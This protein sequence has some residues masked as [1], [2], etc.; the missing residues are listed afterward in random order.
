M[1]TGKQ[2]FVGA[3]EPEHSVSMQREKEMRVQAPLTDMYI[4]AMPGL[5]THPPTQPTALQDAA[6]VSLPVLMMCTNQA[7]PILTLHIASGAA[8]QQQRPETPASSPKPK[9]AGKH[10]CPH[11]GRDC[12]KPSVL[13][14]HLRCHTGERPYPCTTCGISFKTQSNLYKHKRTQ[15]HA[16]LSG[17]T[18]KADFSSQE[19]TE[20]SRETCSSPSLELQREENSGDLNRSDSVLPSTTTTTFSTGILAEGK[21]ASNTE[22]ALR[23]AA[24]VGLIAS[25]AHGQQEILNSAGQTVQSA[26]EAK[27]E[28]P[29]IQT[30]S[31]AGDRR[32]PLTPNRTPLQRQEALFPKLCRGKSQ[33][34]DST[35]SGFSESSEQHLTSSPTDTMHDTSMESLPESNMELQEPGSSKKPTDLAVDDGKSKVSVQ[36]KQ[37]LEEHISKLISENSMLVDDKHLVNVRPRKTVLSKQGSIDLPMP[38]TY[39][40][41]FHFE[42][43]SSKHQVSSLQ[44]QDRRGRAMYSSVPTQHSTSLEHAPLT[45]SSS[46]PFSVGIQ[47][48]DRT[49]FPYQ[50]DSLPLSRRC[51]AGNIYPFKSVDQQAQNHRSLVRQV[52]VDCLSVAE[53]SLVERGSQNSLSSDGDCAD[54][55]TESGVKRCRRKKT[56]KFAYNKW[57]MYGDGTFKK[58]YSTEKDNLLKCRKATPSLEQTENQ[59]IQISQQRDSNSSASV[60]FT[61]CPT[62]S[63][64]AVNT[65]TAQTS[66]PVISSF[67]PLL[68]SPPLT[69]QTTG[70]LQQ[71]LAKHADV[72]GSSLNNE[73]SFMKGTED[74]GKG[75]ETQ[76]SNPIPSERKKPKTEED[77]SVVM[78]NTAMLMRQKRALTSVSR[79]ANVNP[80]DIINQPLQSVCG[81]VF[82]RSSVA[83]VEKDNRLNLH[84]QG[85]F[86]SPSSSNQAQLL[87][88]RHSSPLFVTSVSGTSGSPSATSSISSVSQAKTSFLPKYQLKI[89]GSTDGVSDPCVCNRSSL[90]QS[91]PSKT[92]KLSH[93]SAQQCDAD[94]SLSPTLTDQSAAT[95]MVSQEEQQTILCTAPTPKAKSTAI[96]SVSCTGQNALTPYELSICTST[97][98]IT[99]TLCSFI[100]ESKHVNKLIQ[101]QCSAYMIHSKSGVSSSVLSQ[102]LQTFTATGQNQSVTVS[103][104]HS[105]DSSLSHSS[106][107][108][109]SLQVYASTAGSVAQRNPDISVA[110]TREPPGLTLDTHTPACQS[111]TDGNPQEISHSAFQGAQFEG[112]MLLVNDSQA[113]A[114]DTFYVRTAD[115]QIVMQLISDEQLALIE[116][117]I[118]KVNRGHSFLNKNPETSRTDIIPGVSH[119]IYEQCPGKMETTQTREHSN[120]NTLDKLSD[121]TPT[122]IGSIETNVAMGS[123]NASKLHQNI[124]LTDS[125]PRGDISSQI[126]KE[127]C[128][129]APLDTNA[130]TLGQQHKSLK[131]VC[132]GKHV[133]KDMKSDGCSIS[134]RS[135][136]E[137]SHN[138][139]LSKLPSSH[140]LSTETVG[141]Q[142]ASKSYVEDHISSSFSASTF[143]GVKQSCGAKWN[144]DT[145]KKLDAADTSV[146]SKANSIIFPEVPETVTIENSDHELVLMAA[147]QQMSAEGEMVQTKA[148][149]FV[150]EA[151]LLPQDSISTTASS[152]EELLSSVQLDQPKSCQLAHTS[153]ATVRQ[154]S[155][156]K[157]HMVC[158]Y[159]PQNQRGV[160]NSKLKQEVQGNKSCS[161]SQAPVQHLS[162]QQFPTQG[163]EVTWSN[164]EKVKALKA[165]TALM[166]SAQSNKPASKST[167]EE[168]S[169]CGEAPGVVHSV[170]QEA[171]TGKS[172]TTNLFYPSKAGCPLNEEHFCFF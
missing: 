12:M 133:P 89:P 26:S 116:P 91:S 144:K 32:A 99:P 142:L 16:R 21:T 166:A 62:L 64:P 74:Q 85:S 38:Y 58:L 30:K 14:K 123:K 48:S 141:V 75:S 127:P 113:L 80:L 105:V 36:E 114:Q 148:E 121:T 122:S 115:L 69:K 8:V 27:N 1:A 172:S 67:H 128:V 94:T 56:Q 97:T 135:S 11:C 146:S 119:G 73:A 79:Q 46:L 28:D 87:F 154:M 15:A 139:R 101:N 40:D 138:E 49:V 120:Q 43:R 39:K 158:Q 86:S 134:I 151:L 33:S 117:Q 76:L 9:S 108:T 170:S 131:A 55:S 152:Q 129:P 150:S 61:S 2:G 155:S 95:M 71:G 140:K 111:S 68:P 60:S 4:P 161:P 6:V 157:G 18:G 42:M 84:K 106:T 110:I 7:L 57:Y 19:S 66:S 37:K 109:K 3:A 54:T 160:C 31:P 24:M 107:S 29:S 165:S 72:S 53:G 145:T 126:K 88:K 23:N 132:E 93:Q 171:L 51:S 103:T 163:E 137:Q 44:T 169:E 45:R 167:Q 159:N 20:S 162:Q 118:E 47:N 168:R 102:P 112:K 17:E 164:S 130:T 104:T 100:Q 63:L 5:P 50:G 65:L 78:E 153:L 41:S 149:T 92:P 34:H 70:Q 59:G 81:D 125:C 147:G 124:Y 96:T 156:G 143:S 77:L 10:V 25:P 83:A 136:L 82:Q 90:N 13:E 35:D 52:A 98:I 22:W